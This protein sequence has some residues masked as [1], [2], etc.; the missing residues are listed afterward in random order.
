MTL[1]K[2]YLNVQESA[3]YMGVSLSGFKKMAA[4]L[5]IPFGK[6]PRGNKIY[7]RSDLAKLNEGYFN[8]KGITL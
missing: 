8:A 1:D 3:V 7:R 5:N 4:A 6:V 2:D